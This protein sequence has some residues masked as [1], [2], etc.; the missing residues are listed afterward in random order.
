MMIGLIA[1]G[2]IIVG[3]GAAYMLTREDDSAPAGS[4]QEAGD[5]SA[6]SFNPTSTEEL[7]FKATIATQKDG[8]T[9]TATLEHD[10]QN[11][12]RY[13][14]NLGGQQT[15]VIYTNDAYYTCQAGGTCIKFPISQSANSGFDPS[16]YNYDQSELAGFSDRSYKGKKDCP[17]GTCDVWEVTAGGFT[18]TLY[19][20]SRTK[21][22]T[23]VEGNIAGANSKIVYDYTDVTITVPANAQEINV[24]GAAQ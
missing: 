6:A 17:S 14:S 7:E 20:D 16:A 10:D 8:Q 2:V 13:V 15:E 5:A 3:G 21:R 4:S 24:P 9:M 18:S 22:I 12:S 19:I 23:Q 1:A 11:R